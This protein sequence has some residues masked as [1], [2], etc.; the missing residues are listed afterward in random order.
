MGMSHYPDD[1]SKLYMDAN[2]VPDTGSIEF[3]TIPLLTERIGLSYP[4]VCTVNG[5]I[6]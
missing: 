3:V 1:P 6:D 4:E 5:Y 2:L